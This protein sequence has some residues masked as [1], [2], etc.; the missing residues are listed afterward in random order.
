MEKEIQAG[1]TKIAKV[2]RPTLFTMH[3]SKYHE[4][5]NSAKYSLSGRLTTEYN[6]YVAKAVDWNI[7][8]ATIQLME[9]LERRV[10]EKK[11]ER[12]HRRRGR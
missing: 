11:E 2:S 6:V 9:H 7:N 1:L 12:L 4:K 3:V 10:M 8:R 5:G